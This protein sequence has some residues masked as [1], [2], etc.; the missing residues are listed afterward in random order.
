[1]FSH[2]SFLILGGSSPADIVSLVQGG[3]EIDNCN[4]SLNQ[5]VDAKGRATTRVHGGLMNLTLSQL[6]RQDMIE[7]ALQPRKYRDGVIVMLDSEN[8]PIQK[9]LFERATCVN[10]GI[11]YTQT[12]KTYV[13]T[14]LTIQTSKLILGEGIDVNNEWIED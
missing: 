1:M 2:R 9:I 4:F 11:N 5:G 10:F 13:Q 12:G 7:W 8:T 3:Y 14:S 6:P